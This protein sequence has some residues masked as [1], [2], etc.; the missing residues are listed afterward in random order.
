MM[1]IVIWEKIIIVPGNGGYG[2]DYARGNKA[3]PLIRR[4]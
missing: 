2:G 4:N 3:G 1:K